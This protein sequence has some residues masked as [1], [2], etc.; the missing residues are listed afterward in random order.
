MLYS[1]VCLID[2]K[3]WLYQLCVACHVWLSIDEVDSI[4]QSLFFPCQGHSSLFS[5]SKS[6]KLSIYVNSSGLEASVGNSENFLKNNFEIKQKSD[7]WC[8]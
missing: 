6:N 1:A 2:T 5:D 3:E 8:T 7:E 4:R